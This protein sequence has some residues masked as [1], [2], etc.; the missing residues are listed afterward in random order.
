MNLN[1]MPVQSYVWLK[2]S[3]G[4]LCQVTEIMMFKLQFKMATRL[5][6]WWLQIITTLLP[7]PVTNSLQKEKSK[8]WEFTVPHR[9]KHVTTVYLILT[10]YL[11]GITV[12]K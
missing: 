4:N 7:N 2:R 3:F 12:S 11:V 8:S 10:F 6:N 1:T 9:I 5:D